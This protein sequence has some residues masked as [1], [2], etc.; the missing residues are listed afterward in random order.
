MNLGDSLEA[1]FDHFGP[2]L[3]SNK[4]SDIWGPP[5]ILRGGIGSKSGKK[6]KK[7]RFFKNRPKSCPDGPK[8][9][10]WALE[11]ENRPREPQN[12]HFLSV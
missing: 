6:R 4:I 1:I 10:L 9:I 12:T 3:L 8:S 11:G 7:N 2:I 5:Q